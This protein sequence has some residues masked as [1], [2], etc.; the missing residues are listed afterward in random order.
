MKRTSIIAS[1]LL[2]SIIA[3]KSQQTFTRNNAGLQGNAGATSGFF[4]TAAP[5]NYPA[6]ASGWWHLLDVRHTNNDN[7]FGM[8][9]SGSFFDQQLY[10]RKT[11]NNPAQSWSRVLLE[12]N[13]GVTT[14]AS[15]GTLQSPGRFHITG[16]EKLFL[17]NKQ[18]VVIGKD[19]GGTGDLSVQGIASIGAVTSVPAG[20][21]LY[22]ANGILTEKVKV[23]VKTSADWA[24]YVFDKNYRLMPLDQV[25]GF[26]KQH[27]HLPGIASATEMVKEG[28]DLA[29]TDAKLLAKIEEL[30][31]YVIALN[32][33][34]ETQQKEIALLKKQ[35]QTP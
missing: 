17:L 22:V 12:G 9:F 7:N 16:E 35:Q 32:Q 2:C 5:V 20:Y 1:L 8:Q 18:G 34:I 29:Q 33:K 3:A 26:I 27:K 15:Q 14:V 31:L 4:E 30:T 19:W 10:F 24:D 13:N 25:A 21:N 6:G 11:A 23:A 28:N